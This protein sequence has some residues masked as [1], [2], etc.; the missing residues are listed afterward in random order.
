MSKLFKA[1][2][3]IISV[4]LIMGLAVGVIGASYMWGAP[5]I[6][7]S[8]TETSLARAEKNIELINS[9]ITD[10]V[11][12]GGQKTK[13]IQFDGTLDIIDSTYGNSIIYTIQ[14]KTAGVASTNWILLNDDMPA[15]SKE[16]YV[17]KAIDTSDTTSIGCGDCMM[18]S[19]C[20]TNA[21]EITGTCGGADVVKIHNVGESFTCDTNDYL[22]ERVDCGG[23]ID[24]FAVL[25]GP[26]KDIAGIVG[27]NKAGVITAKSMA[28][29]DIYL[30]SYK[31]TFRELVDPTNKEGTIILLETRGNNRITAGMHTIKVSRGETKTETYGSSL[32]GELSKT[33]VLITLE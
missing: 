8:Q 6:E 25:S 20:P 11:K 24:G 32:V 12:T 22:V 3:Q 2:T 31:L 5:L 16:T 4:V 1:Q 29:G 28:A 15:I 13:Q 10:V 27:T 33:I 19:V 17:V 30:T 26:E 7:K 18:N 14:G 21:I 9:M 23:T